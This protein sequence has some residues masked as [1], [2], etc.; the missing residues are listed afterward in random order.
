MTT[1]EVKVTTKVNKNGSVSFGFSMTG[2]DDEAVTPNTFNWTHSDINEDPINGKEAV[3]GTPGVI[4][5]VDLRDDD[6]ALPGTSGI[7]VVT[8]YGTMNTTRDGVAQLNDPYTFYL[9][10]NICDVFNIPPP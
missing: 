2:K 1:C 6:L 3:V 9:K 8:I 4:S 10:Y 7:R 5:W